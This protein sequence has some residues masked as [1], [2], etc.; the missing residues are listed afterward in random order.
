V[1]TRAA[2]GIWTLALACAAGAAV[3]VEASDHH[4]GEARDAHPGDPHRPRLHRGRILARVQRPDNRTGTLLILVGFA[5]TLGALT[6]SDND[7]VFTIGLLVGTLFTRSSRTCFSRFRPAGSRPA[8]T[9]SSHTRSTPSR[10][11]DRRSRSCS[12][13]VTWRRNPC[14]GDSP[15]PDNLIATF[16]NQTVANAILIAY[17][18]SSTILA[19]AVLVRLVQRWRRASPPLR[20]ALFPSS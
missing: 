14:A 1:S 8:P 18:L 19:G 4:L 6:T 3:M 15:C 10:S 11:S 9:A 13:R 7:V 16:P 17:A 5:W 20:R 2:L 12:T